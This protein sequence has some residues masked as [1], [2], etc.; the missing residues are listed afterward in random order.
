MI[1][2]RNVYLN[3]V[4]PEY[5]AFRISQGVDTK[6]DFHFKRQNGAVLNSDVVAQL[7]VTS[8][9][10]GTTE[11]YSCPAIDVVNG[12]ARAVIPAGLGHDPNGYN[13]R[14]TGTVDQ[15]PRVLAYGVMTAI[16]GA[17]PQV[18]AQDVIDSIDLNLF[19]GQPTTVTVTLWQDAGKS[20]PYDLTAK[21]VTANIRA[22]PTGGVLQPF[23]V[24]SIS[25]NAVTIALTAEQV[26]SLPASAWWS[27]VVTSSLGSTTLAQGDV[28]VKIVT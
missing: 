26:D 20:A 4:E 25:A 6:V 17:G 15:E 21:T 28:S 7:Q 16:A 8:R 13:L 2:H 18:E 23:T 19:Y 27:L 24:A 11:Y 10:R 22:S 9:S 5:L 1:L 3:T 14:L 12:I